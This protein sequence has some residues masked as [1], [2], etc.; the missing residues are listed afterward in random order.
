[1]YQRF[2]DELVLPQ[3]WSG[4]LVLAFRKNGVPGRGGSVFVYGSPN[5]LDLLRFAGLSA[6]AESNKWDLQSVLR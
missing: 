5:M 4:P 1:M 3:G 6:L 2:F